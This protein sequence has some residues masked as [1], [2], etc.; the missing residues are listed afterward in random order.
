M[1]RIMIVPNPNKDLEFNI[2]KR[3][4]DKLSRLG[5]V[6]NMDTR[7]SKFG[8]CDVNYLDD[9]ALVS[10][11][12]IVIGGDGSVIDASLDA[13][14]CDI[15]LLGINLGRIGYLTELEPDDLDSLSK[16]N[17]GEYRIVER[18]LLSSEKQGFGGDIT[19]LAVNIETAPTH[20]AGLPVAVNV[21]C[22]VTRHKE[23]VI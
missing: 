22:H 7:Y 9:P 12:I 15:P 11:L 6:I 23:A 18:M 4:I 1:K 13:V 8:F 16:I 21:G 2:T 3:T 5:F 10:D 20:I 17:C 14:R 19:A